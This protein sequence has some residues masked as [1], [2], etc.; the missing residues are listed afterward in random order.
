MRALD[1]SGE[2]FGRL[3]A[4]KRV[5]TRSGHA[6]WLCSCDCG[7]NATT[8]LGELRKGHTRSCGC[9]RAESARQCGALADG[10]A[11][12]THGCSKLPEY[13]IWKT[14][15]QRATG[16]GT[17]KDRELYRGVKC[18]TRWADFACFLADMGLRPSPAHSLDRIDNAKGYSPKNCRWSTPTEQANNRRKR[19]TTADVLAARAAH[20]EG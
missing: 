17:A 4:V 13:A 1:V 15:R 8:T 9:L 11:N 20:Q 7:G 6:V 12:V 10:S 2:R 18:C 14:M 5:G 19:R 16:K 3:I